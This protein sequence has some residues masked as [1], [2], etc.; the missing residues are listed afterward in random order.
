M[1]TGVGHD[2]RPRRAPRCVEPPPNGTRWSVEGSI[3]PGSDP[4]RATCTSPTRSGFVPVSL[5]KRSRMAHAADGDRGRTGARSVPT[6]RRPAGWRSTIP[7]SRPPGRRR[8]GERCRRRPDRPRRGAARAGDVASRPVRP[9]RASA[10]RGRE[11]ARRRACRH[12]SPSSLRAR[13]GRALPDPPRDLCVSRARRS[14]C[15][16]ATVRR[17]R[18]LR[19]SRLR[20]HPSAGAPRATSFACATTT[21][22][23]KA[24]RITDCQ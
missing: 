2:G 6:R 15:G 10:G 8:G 5:E 21:S 9:S 3:E 17:K 7:S 4:G 22:S 19:R 20:P 23:R 24:P 18:H 12:R 1:S 13:A 14:R 16:A 11:P